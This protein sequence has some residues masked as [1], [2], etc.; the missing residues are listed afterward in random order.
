MNEIVHLRL[1]YMDTQEIANWFGLYYNYFKH[2]KI[3]EFF[4]DDFDF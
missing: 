1:G 2:K 3:K 4:T